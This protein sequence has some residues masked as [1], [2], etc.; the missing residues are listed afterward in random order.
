MRVLVTGSEGYIGAVLAPM[1]LDRGLDVVGLDTGFYRD[2]WLFSR[3][4]RSFPRCI[5]KDIR[6]LVDA[7]LAGFDAV[8]HLAELSND[9]LCQHNPDTTYKINHL[10]TVHL[11][12]A[13]AGRTTVERAELFAGDRS[14]VRLATVTA[15]LALGLQLAAPGAMAGDL[16]AQAKQLAVPARAYPELTRIN[17]QVAAL[18]T[19][20]EANTNQLKE[21]R[22]ARIRATSKRY[23]SLTREFNQSRNRLS[24]LERK[25]EKAPSLDVNRFP[26]PAGSDR[27][28]VSADV[29]RERAMAGEN[30]KY[31]QAKASLKQCLK[32]LSD[33]YDEQLREIASL[34]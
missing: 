26:V 27:G 22:Q 7:D 16:L 15:A 13:R 8:V 31:D 30:K 9:P 28:S 33:H 12:L 14:A 5:A 24:E 10:G 19:R 23:S 32:T 18:I 3:R 34:R 2:G 29:L 21:Y 25:L 17:D 20:M 11:A 4:G 6:D 1:L